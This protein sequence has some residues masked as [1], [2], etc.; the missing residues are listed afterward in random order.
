MDYGISETRLSVRWGQ[1]GHN[2]MQGCLGRIGNIVGFFVWSK[3]ASFKRKVKF[4]V[5]VWA[6]QFD[7]V[8]ATVNSVVVAMVDNKYFWMLIIATVFAFLLARTQCMPSLNHNA[9][10]WGVLANVIPVFMEALT[11]AE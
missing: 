1:Y 9:G 8:I 3:S 7:I 5:T 10:T 2:P 6:Q 4:L 11:R